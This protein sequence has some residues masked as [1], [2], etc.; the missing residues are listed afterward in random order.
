MNARGKH[1]ATYL[2]SLRK[3]MSKQGVGA[4]VRRQTLHKTVNERKRWRTMF[5]P[6][7]K[8]EKKKKGRQPVTLHLR[9]IF[10]GGAYMILL[11]V[12]RHI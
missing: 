12:C 7:Q 8:A 1:R 5:A 9:N 2:I 4:T 3:R 10:L 11:Y 6:I